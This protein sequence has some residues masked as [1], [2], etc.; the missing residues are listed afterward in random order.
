MP[1]PKGS[2]NK[3]TLAKEI[4]QKRS[5][6]GLSNPNW[7]GGTG[8]K[9]KYSAYAPTRLAARI[10]AAIEDP[11]RLSMSQE[12]AL[13]D[14]RIADVLQRVDTG[15]AGR[16][17][18]Q[19]RESY[20]EFQD[21]SKAM[22][23]AAMTKALAAL[24]KALIKGVNDYAAW[25]EVLGLINQRKS[26]VESERK[27]ILE[28]KQYLDFMEVGE[29]FRELASLIRS[30]VTDQATLTKLAHGMNDLMERKSGSRKAKGTGPAAPEPGELR[31]VNIDRQPESDGAITV[32]TIS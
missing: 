4:G 22:D 21:A 8:T 30:T 1:R 9:S 27:R 28:A 11:N 14:G 7:K 17:W 13:V 19:A 32:S 16:L 31:V 6:P 26:L 10:E 18:K 29:L 5:K 15:E 2:K 24:D 12:L 20:E 25:G 3:S 23:K